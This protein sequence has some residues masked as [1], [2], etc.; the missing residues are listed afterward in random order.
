MKF[1]KHIKLMNQEHVGVEEN[2]LVD[3]VAKQATKLQNYKLPHQDLMPHFRKKMI[4]K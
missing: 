2:E 1:M 4:N 3:A